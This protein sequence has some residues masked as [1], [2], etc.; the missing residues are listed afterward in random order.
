[1]AINLPRRYPGD[2]P[3]NV[4]NQ[5]VQPCNTFTVAFNQAKQV[6]QCIRGADPNNDLWQPM[7]FEVSFMWI[8]AKPEQFL[9]ELQRYQDKLNNYI[10]ERVHP[11][12]V[13]WMKT[14]VKAM[15]DILNSE[16]N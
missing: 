15:I 11:K 9:S 10:G 12:D 14:Y 2:F 3:Q 6:A 5:N 8:N 16:L 1:M 7:V 4:P 13:Q